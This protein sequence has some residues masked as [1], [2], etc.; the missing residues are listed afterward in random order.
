[1][2][3]DMSQFHGVFIEESQEH[4]DEMEHLLLALDP[5]S[6]DIEELN[7]IFRAAHSIKGGSGMFSFDALITVTHVMESLFDKARQ[8]KFNFSVHIIDELLIAVD[9]LRKLLKSYADSTEIEWALVNSTT[10]SLEVIL[11]PDSQAESQDDENGFGFFK[12]LNSSNKSNTSEIM[13]QVNDD[14]DDGFGFFEPLVDDVDDV[15][16]STAD[17]ED[18]FGFFVDLD[19]NLPDSNLSKQKVSNY[20]EEAL[21]TEVEASVLHDT[22]DRKSVV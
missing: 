6:P 19:D 9:T 7:S 8:G 12:P 14:T 20:Q 10:A 17:I 5:S 21:T 11:E 22:T 13:P 15:D 18:G 4:L 2:S 16:E 3:M 1:M